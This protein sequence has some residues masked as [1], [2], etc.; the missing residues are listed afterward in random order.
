[1]LDRRAITVA[2]PRLR[3]GRASTRRRTPRAWGVEGLEGRAL[4]SVYM[5]NSLGDAGTG[6]GFTGDLRYAINQADQATDDS[7]IV[8]APQ[9]YGKTIGLGS[10]ALAINKPSGTLSILGGGGTAGPTISAGGHGQVLTIS[11]FSH[12]S[13]RGV[14]LSGGIGPGG[15]AILND[16][17][18][19]L[20]ACTITGNTAMGG[21]GGGI[22]NSPFGVM[23][24]SESTIS[25]NEST[26]GDG[27]GIDNLGTMT[28]QASTVSGN[29]V[30]V[31]D[32]GGVANRGMLSIGDSTISGNHVLISGDGGGIS[33][34]SS[35]TLT[36]DTIGANTAQGSGGGVANQ[37]TQGGAISMDNTIV[38][39]N[40]SID[41]PRTGDIVDNGD[42]GGGRL[43][44]SHDLVRSGDV[45][46]LTHTLVA[47]D[48]RLGPLQN[49]GGPTFT[50]SISLGSPAA[51][52]GDP[53]LVPLGVTTDQRGQPYSRVV[54]GQLDIGA[55]EIQA[56]RLG[57]VLPPIAHVPV[58]R[59]TEVLVGL[60]ILPPGLLHSTST[61]TA[62]AS[63]TAS[64]G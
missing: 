40:T 11:P 32:G 60:T 50:Q 12:V 41:I 25:G 14:T 10:G 55:F 1:M 62:S 4:L 9:L 52:A 15:G 19:T 37:A 42:V 34:V 36:D 45:G 18:L 57:V 46:S 13:I 3:S 43:M 49:N 51:G 22:Y 8:F 5:V 59:P 58:P 2:W 54:L 29:T 6:K 7:T 61:T 30:T 64:A 53:A 20:V 24:I 47:V 33:N 39:D 17:K 27:G 28:I 21:G 35:L 48:P 38:A 63:G 23:S 44:G 31:G 16:G 26:L 56:V